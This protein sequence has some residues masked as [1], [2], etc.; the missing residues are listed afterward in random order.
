MEGIVEVAR[1]RVEGDVRRESVDEQDGGRRADD[2]TA[3][4]AGRRSQQPSEH[5]LHARVGSV[6]T[7]SLSSSRINS[8]ARPTRQPSPA[9]ATRSARPRASRPRVGS[10]HGSPQRTALGA[11]RCSARDSTSGGFRPRLRRDL[12]PCP[13]RA[14]A[15][16]PP[17]RAAQRSCVSP[18]RERD[19]RRGWIT[20]SPRE[21]SA[22]RPSFPREAGAHPHTV[23]HAL[24]NRSRCG[25]PALPEVLNLR[26]SRRDRGAMSAVS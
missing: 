19:Q 7:R 13:G 14:Y 2:G 16:R 22:R 4:S 18:T 3:S 20:G 21:S 9:T 25:A 15:A 23:R 8:D 17:R 24:R 1:D 26:S 11:A 5:D 10:R 12:T 6:S